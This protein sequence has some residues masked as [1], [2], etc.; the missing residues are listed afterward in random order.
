[1]L[2]SIDIELDEFGNIKKE[3]IIRLLTP[4]IYNINEFKK[5]IKDANDL[6]TYLTL[7]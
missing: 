6:S 3:D 5:K 4:T 7:N 1:M 2:E